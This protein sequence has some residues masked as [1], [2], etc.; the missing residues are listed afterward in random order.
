MPIPN[1]IPITRAHHR[2]THTAHH[3]RIA[4]RASQITPRTSPAQNP[5]TRKLTSH[6]ATRTA[7]FAE[8][9]SRTP[10]YASHA[11]RRKRHNTRQSTSNIICP[12]A[13]LDTPPI[14]TQHKLPPIKHRTSSNI[15]VRTSLSTCTAHVSVNI[16]HLHRLRVQQCTQRIVHPSPLAYRRS[17]HPT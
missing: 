7:H 5:A 3:T 13:A 6:H 10:R 1:G 17:T 11:Q 4:H 16:A 15:T 12:R 8:I 9:T 2:T 14:I